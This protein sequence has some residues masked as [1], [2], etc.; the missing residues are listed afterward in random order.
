MLDT[1]L[2]LIETASGTNRLRGAVE[3]EREEK[4]GREEGGDGG[5]EGQRE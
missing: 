5:K 1:L 2:R 4:E 3:R